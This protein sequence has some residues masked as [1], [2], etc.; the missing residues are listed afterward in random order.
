MNQYVAQN[1]EEV[2]SFAGGTYGY[3]GEMVIYEC[4]WTEQLSRSSTVHGLRAVA[5]GTKARCNAP[6]LARDWQAKGPESP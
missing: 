1:C 6:Q 2:Q 5:F 3:K 4:H